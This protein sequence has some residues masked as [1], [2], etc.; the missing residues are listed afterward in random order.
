MLVELWI[1][2][3]FHFL[4]LPEIKK[5]DNE[6]CKGYEAIRTHVFCTGNSINILENALALF[7][8]VKN[9]SVLWPRKSL[10]DK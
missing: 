4:R 6:C 10:L 8:R 1:K 3:H 2:Y 7:C 9:L 5:P